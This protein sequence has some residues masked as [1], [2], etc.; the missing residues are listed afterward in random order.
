[1]KNRRFVIV[2][3]NFKLML[4]VCHDIFIIDIDQCDWILANILLM[5]INNATIT[6]DS[7]EH[8]Q[9]LLI[10]FKLS[11]NP[12]IRYDSDYD[13]DEFLLLMGYHS[14]LNYSE[15][16]GYVTSKTARS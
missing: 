15:F 16:Y 7:D 13:I 4:R 10:K 2:L 6:F 8:L 5:P 1:M 14:P 12:N 9:Q 11:H 3:H